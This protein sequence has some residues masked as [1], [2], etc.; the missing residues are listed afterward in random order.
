MFL[1]G[2]VGADRLAPKKTRPNWTQLGLAAAVGAAV[3]G[4]IWAATSNKDKIAGMLGVQPEANGQA[5]S[6][7]QPLDNPAITKN[8]GVGNP[9]RVAKSA[10]I[11]K[12]YNVKPSNS[13]SM[14]YDSGVSE[15]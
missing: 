11:L 4:G 5:P 12:K 7:G 2:S 6:A 1:K 10:E 15:F 14:K 13:I 8:D 9:P 3:I